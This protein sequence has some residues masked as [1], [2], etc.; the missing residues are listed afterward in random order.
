MPVENGLNPAAQGTVA[1]WK[2]VPL[3]PTLDMQKAYF[4]EVDR[5]MERV[6]TDMRFGRFDNHRLAYCA[7]LTASPPAPEALPA[8]GVDVEAIA[9]I[10]DPSSWEAYDHAYSMQIGEFRRCADRAIKPSLATAEYVITALTSA[11][12][13]EDRS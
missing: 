11:P 10:I 12:A 5:N 7:M 4:D 6:E 13:P 2:L 3:T 9:R 1:G 8:S